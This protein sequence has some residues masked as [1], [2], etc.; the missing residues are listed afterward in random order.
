MFHAPLQTI[1]VDYA[2]LENFGVHLLMY[3]EEVR[4]LYGAL[5]ENF[6]KAVEIVAK[7]PE[8]YVACM[9]NFTA[10]TL[11]PERYGEF[12]LPVYQEFFP[13]LQQAGK[14]V[15]TH[16][17]GRI[18]ACKDLV[19][20]APIDVVESFTPPPEGDMTL[21]EARNAWPTKLLWSNINVSVYQLDPKA[22]RQRV[23]HSVQEA[24]PDGRKLAFEV[25]E[26]IPQNW[27][28]SIPVILDALRETR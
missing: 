28:E 9:E 1:L 19:A 8:R 12:L 10:D 2:G 5:R 27:R 11:G 17:D 13:M 16:Y 23:L 14:V 20:E 24:A 21:A 3:E 25:S 22:L 6:R 26:H 18:S 4:G 7:S 15:G